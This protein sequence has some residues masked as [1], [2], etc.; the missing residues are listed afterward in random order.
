MKLSAPWVTF[1]RELEALFAYDEEVKVTYDEEAVEVKIYVDNM[2]KADALTE[3]LPTEKVFGNVTLKINVVPSNKVLTK[4]DLISEAFNGNPA[5]AYIQHV[6]SLIGSFDYAVFEPKVVQFYNDN[7]QDLNGLKSTLYEDIAKD[8]F[9]EDISVFF[10]TSPL[11]RE[12]AKPLG[13][14]P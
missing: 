5:L 9:G 4:A 7:M 12:L 13:E 14:W 10:C 3:L 8:V 2:R 11:D 1:Y 6:D